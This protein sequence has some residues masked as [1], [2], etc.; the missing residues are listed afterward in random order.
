V[1]S[2]KGDESLIEADLLHVRCGALAARTASELPK[3]LLLLLLRLVIKRKLASLTLVGFTSDRSQ[4]GRENSS[5]ATVNRR[6]G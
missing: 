1:L 4:P 5:V 2:E 6:E 3:W